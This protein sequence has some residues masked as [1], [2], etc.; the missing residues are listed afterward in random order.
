MIEENRPQVAKVTAEA[1][2]IAST[3]REQVERIGEMLHDAG[4]RA[5]ERLEQIDHSVESTVEQVEAVGENVKR[6]VCG[7]CGKST[8]SP[9]ASPPPSPHWSKVTHRSSVDSAT[10][11][12]EMFI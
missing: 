9:P 12:E 3:G 2:R 11:D 1:A 4:D 6:A 7:L 5:K 10:Q 8:G